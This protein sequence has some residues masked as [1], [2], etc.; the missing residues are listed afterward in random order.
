MLPWTT[1]RTCPV[2]FRRDRHDAV[3][4]GQKVYIFGCSERVPSDDRQM[5]V[6]VFNTV[7]L[8]WIELPPVTTGRGKP[9]L[10][11]PSMRHGPTAVLVDNMAYIWGGYPYC[12]ALYAFDVDTHG[13]FKPEVSGSVPLARYGHSACLSGKVMYVFGGHTQLT[14]STN[15]IYKLDTAAMVWSFIDAGGTPP[16]ASE[17]HSATIIGT[18]MFVFGGKVG[19]AFDTETDCWLRKP[20]GNLLP[21]RRSSHS[22]FAYNGELYIFGGHRRRQEYF[23][24]LWKFNPE[25]WSWKEV[26]RKKE[27][28]RSTMCC[29]CIVGDCVILFG[30]Y[31]ALFS[32]FDL[33]I[34]DLC[35]TL[36]TL[37]K[38]AVIKYKLDQSELPHGIKWELGLHGARSR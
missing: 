24:D 25:T 10:E 16:P 21:E 19:R 7:S 13:W 12:N 2:L 11:G 37:C 3:V 8:C 26:Q 35:P 29:C 14:G 32:F 6:H 17:G 28:G 1:R 15:D 31:N 30:G 27:I 18:K 23:Y 34:L 5:G 4:V 38:L 33:F 36:K 9:P 20:S 22:A